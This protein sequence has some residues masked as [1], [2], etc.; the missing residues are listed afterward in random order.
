MIS[1]RQARARDL[2]LLSVGVLLLAYIIVRAITV[3]ISI[4]EAGTWQM[5]VSKG[6]IFPSEYGYFSANNH[7]LNTALMMLSEKLFGS[8]V[9]ALRLPNVLAG[10]L[11]IFSTGMMARRFPSALLGT[12]AF[13]VMN[14]NPFMIQY[15]NMARGYGL[16]AGLTAFAF[17]QLWKYFDDGA[18]MKN[19]FAAAL[20][21]SL[22]VMAN[23]IYLNVFLP[24]AGFTF[25][26]ILLHRGEKQLSKRSRWTHA[27]TISAFGI[28]VLAV[29][30]PV[31]NAI[32]AGGG[33]WPSDWEEF[34]TQ[35]VASIIDG[36]LFDAGGRNPVIIYKAMLFAVEIYFA[37]SII[38]L[39]RTF[40]MRKEGERSFF[41]LFVFTTLTLSVIAV[42]LQHEWFDI[43]YPV[44][45]IGLFMV[46]PLLLL[47][48]L[49]AS[50]KRNHW[51]SV[52]PF[53]LLTAL[54]TW[55]FTSTASSWRESF[56]PVSQQI[57]EAIAYM[58]EHTPAGERIRVT[59]DPVVLSS[60]LDF[61]QTTLPLLEFDVMRDTS[62]HNPLHRYC[63][64]SQEYV[65]RV[66]TSFWR[67]CRG[68]ANGNILFESTFMESKPAVKQEV[69]IIADTAIV[70]SESQ[71]DFSVRKQWP[72]STSGYML[73]HIEMKIRRA[74]D[75]HSRM[76]I[77]MR[78]DD[79]EV[80]VYGIDFSRY[81]AK[82][83]WYDMEADVVLPHVEAEDYVV[84]P[85][86]WET[87]PATEIKNFTLTLKAY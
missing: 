20:A 45:R 47:V 8:S 5:F 78:R 79:Q 13:V 51:F 30:I 65:P 66:D 35:A 29:V 82:D 22:A 77:T 42:L 84:V 2:F 12:L 23:F 39:G 53:A 15:F 57:N 76:W 40:M 81:P 80:F 44:Q 71:K 19:L 37:A 54:L 50:T 67:I 33:F 72:D 62:F 26:F 46:W 52:A 85:M 41:P 25:L 68:F 60:G 7:A 69:S 58:Q 24:L 56:N 16:A 87:G 27:T 17:W 34:W 10:A 59:A 49:A 6:E 63:F 48:S 1:A 86:Y 83:E 73:L 18:A 3:S 61:Y 43:E 9:F 28:A 32:R 31:S 70:L 64:V 55:H 4:D 74:E 38:V 21:A 11:Y 36:V 14:T 75:S